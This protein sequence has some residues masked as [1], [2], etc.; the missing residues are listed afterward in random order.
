MATHEIV[1]S[2][3]ANK[4]RNKEENKATTEEEEVK[5]SNL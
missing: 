2:K 3:L 5:T 1:R 4:E